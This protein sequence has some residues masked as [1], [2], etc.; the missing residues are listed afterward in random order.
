MI[1]RRLA[2]LSVAALALGLALHSAQAD[3]PQGFV[4][5]LSDLQAEAGGAAIGRVMPS[6]PLVVKAHKDGYV[7]AE[8]TGW[9]PAGGDKYLFKAIGTRINAVIL[10][11]QGLDHR[12][13]GETQEDDYGSDWQKATVTGWLPEASVT[14]DLDSIWKAAG[15]IY[16]SR[17]TRCHSL[18]RP[19]DFTANQ[20]PQVLKVMTVRA[21]LSAEQAAL[22]TM[23]LQSHAK[24][25]QVTDAFTQTAATQPATAPPAVKI[26]GTPELAAKGAELFKTANCF[27]CHGEDAKTPATP[28]IPRLAGQTAEY[29]LKQIG[30]FKS[31]ARANDTTAAMKDTVAPLSDDEVK[32]IVYWLSTN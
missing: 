15:D 8:I 16:F 22:V 30:D 27:A 18:R 17:C 24:D 7:Q 20:W 5:S 12:S 10:N 14:P 21:G 28:E 1:F 4:A 23:L 32:A 11:D 19:G 29:L 31:G 6:T 26:D 2:S 3:D 13:G 9:S 25:Q